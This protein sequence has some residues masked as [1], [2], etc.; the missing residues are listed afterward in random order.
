MQPFNECRP[1]RYG[2][3]IYNRNDLYVGKSLE[4]YGEF[5]EIEVSA[6]CE[7]VKPGDTVLDIGANIGCMTVPLAQRVGPEGAVFAFEPNRLTFMN[8]CGNAAL[9]SLRNVFCLPVGVGKEPGTMGY[10]EY[11]PETSLN[12]GGLPMDSGLPTK[13]AIVRLDSMP[14][15][16]CALIKI[17]VEGMET[18]VLQGAEQT[19]GKF[20]PLLYV[21][22]DRPEREA[23]LLSTLCE[24]RYRCFWHITPLF[25]PSNFAGNREDVFP[26]IV[27]LNMLCLP[28]EM[29]FDTAN[30]P[31]VKM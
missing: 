2:K 4:L 24:L 7:L 5:S 19:I 30:L 27:S 20:R 16:D 28:V 13:T 22:N 1:C 15:P 23:D 18:E 6:L 8:L 31:A 12:I 25:N 11:D 21:E 29:D 17:D 14:L 26:G 9:N 10:L 3:M